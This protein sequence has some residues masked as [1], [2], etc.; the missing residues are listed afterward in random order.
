MAPTLIAAIDQGTT[1]TRCIIFDLDAKI[2]ASAQREHQQH[3]AQPGWVE[4]D[5]AEIRQSTEQCIRDAV[6]KCG[7]R[8]QAIAAVGVTNQ[9]ETIVFWDRATGRPLTRAIVWQDTRTQN[10][11]NQ[12]TR[13][14]GNDRIRQITG[15]PFSTYFSGP[16]IRWALDSISG[17]RHACEAGTALCGTMESW[18]IWNLTGGPHGG[19]GGVHITDVTNASRT[20]LMNLRTLQWDDEILAAMKIPVTIL[21]RIVPCTAK[22]GFG[23]TTRDGPFGRAIPI[24]G[25]VGDQ[26]AALVGQ[27]CFN[28][29]DAKNTYGT[30]CFLLQNTGAELVHSRAG[31][32]TTVAYQMEGAPPAYALEGSV[33]IAGALVQ[34]LRDNLGIIKSSSEIEQLAGA[35]TDNGGV[36]IVPAFS[37]LFAPHWRPDARGI[38]AGLTRFADKSHIARAAIE[39][40]CFQT[41]DV[42][43]AM[44]ADSGLSLGELRV[45]GGMVANDLLMQF[46][47]D[48]L[49]VPV[50]RPRITETT[51]LGAAFAAGLAIGA[52]QNAES[53]RAT[54][55]VDRTWQPR[56][57]DKE[58]QRLLAGW[59]RA[60]EHSL[61]WIDVEQ[62]A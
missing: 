56:M 39:A 25:S 62:H 1:S 57:A 30:G 11:C 10:L 12:L 15:L 55:Q 3:Y 20:Q 54:W 28:P 46:Q 48:L 17:L 9:R 5:A 42:F 31:L 8:A 29:G 13:D 24:A 50:V 52:W 40:V 60:V 14:F 16:K 58:R 37:G 47:A 53:L 49:Q 44:R 41:R 6:A 7:N 2:I 4:H 22:A 18:T 35:A 32:L 21:P 34:W 45:D 19:G 51:A 27:C 23:M 36:Y 43:E 38:I 33:A 59:Q 26:Q 61:N